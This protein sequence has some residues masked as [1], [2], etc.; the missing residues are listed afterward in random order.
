MLRETPHYA[1]EASRKQTEILLNQ[2]R[3]GKPKAKSSEFNYKEVQKT[4]A[5]AVAGNAELAVVDALVVLGASVDVSRRAST[6]MFKRLNNTDQ[7]DQRCIVLQNATRDGTPGMV[8]LLA[9]HAVHSATLDDALLIAVAQQD[10]EKT[11]ILLTTGI[12]ADFSAAHRPFIGAIGTGNVPLVALLLAATPA[13]RGPCDKCKADGLV[14]AVIGGLLPMV[15]MLLAADADTT[16]NDAQAFKLATS[17]SNWHIALAIAAAKR[18]LTP[19]QLDEACAI[20]FTSAGSEANRRLLLQICLAAGATGPN[21]QS[22]LQQAVAHGMFDVVRLLLRYGTSM[23]KDGGSALCSAVEQEQ[24]DIFDALLQAPASIGTLSSALTLTSKAKKLGTDFAYQL[25]NK[26]ASPDF[27]NGASLILA[28]QEYRLDILPILLSYTR[29]SSSKDNALATVFRLLP[30]QPRLDCLSV[31]LP[32]HPSEAQLNA[33]LATVA[34]ERPGDHAAI[35]LLLAHGA[36]PDADQGK[37]FRQA[38]CAHDVQLLELLAVSVS[39]IEMIYSVAAEDIIKHTFWR[40]PEGFEALLW[41]LDGGATPA[42]IEEAVVQ[43]A[44]NF[45]TDALG[46]LTDWELSTDIY[47]VAFAET[48]AQGDQWLQPDKFAIMQTLLG[49]GARGEPVAGALV[50][51]IE[52]Y[53]SGDAQETVM[54]TLLEHGA[55]VN[56]LNGQALGIAVRAGHVGLLSKLCKSTASSDALTT[57]LCS[58]FLYEHK[59]DVV[60]GLMDVLVIRDEHKAD[61]NATIG[62]M[63]SPIYLALEHYPKDSSIVRRLCELGCDVEIQCKYKIYGEEPPERVVRRLREKGDYF[64]EQVEYATDEKTKKMAIEQA[65]EQYGNAFQLAKKEL[66]PTNIDRLKLCY[67]ISEFHARILGNLDKAM[68]FARRAIEDAAISGTCTD[69]EAGETLD[70]LRQRMHDLQENGIRTLPPA[71]QQQQPLHVTTCNCDECKV[72][73]KTNMPCQCPSCL[74]QAATCPCSE[75]RAASQALVL[76]KKGKVI[77]AA[78]AKD[79]VCAEPPDSQLE[80][81]KMPAEMVTPLLFACCQVHDGAVS[82]S[83]VDTL[84]KFKANVN[85]MTTHSATTP[86]L[87]ATRYQRPDLVTALLKGKPDTS[88]KDKWLRSPLFYAARHGDKESVR[89]LLKTKPRVNDGSVHE[90]ARSLHYDVLSQL[91]KAGHDPNFTSTK[92]DGLTP[93]GELAMY[94]D[95]HSPPSTIESCIHALLNKKFRIDPLKKWHG[96]TALYLAMR[97][98]VALSIT[99]AVV[100]GALYDKMNDP[101][102][103]IKIEAFN[104]SP[105]MYIQ[106]GFFVGRPED[107]DALLKL[108][109]LHSTED[110]FYADEH[111][112]FQPPGACGLPVELEKAERRRKQHQQDLRNVWQKH[113]QQLVLKD[114]LQDQY[115]QHQDQKQQQHLRHQ[116]ERSQQQ[117]HQKIR[118][119]ETKLRLLQN[120]N[121][122]AVHHRKTVAELKAYENIQAVQHKQAV[123]RQEAVAEARK[124]AHTN[125]M[126]TRQ[127]QNARVVADIKEKQERKMMKINARKNAD[128]ARASWAKTNAKVKQDKSAVWALK[129][130]K[131]ARR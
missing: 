11:R 117:E 83:V 61:L 96:M 85:A 8:H 40:C 22:V 5:A 16:H 94:C 10:V 12:G 116:A 9:V 45:D 18:P 120:E 36:S 87:L 105:T 41:L 72:A 78:M 14:E 35:K 80:E 32:T 6:N 113:Q 34:C 91:L 88:I 31:L 20:A 53:V 57:A 123:H 47:S 25:L 75:C 127:E 101:A 73:A 92:H 39:N 2:C 108:L 62:G 129:Q 68:D 19:V 79:G 7:E 51:A 128:S 82:A 29:K 131:K 106:S 30:G 33:C 122:Q 90:A 99:R 81:T 71:R 100:E 17:T 55:D 130:K 86:L 121:S 119:A 58:A 74:E 26:G 112:A 110:A 37:A 97:N 111:L 63:M 114:Q 109:R 125:Q 59:S 52:A 43:A 54:D 84:L 49:R 89:A 56:Y 95:G 21:C 60:I 107:R 42:M 98:P 23:D 124:L 38:A 50:R 70:S 126:K 24:K 46:L 115:L 118:G 76:Y 64:A 93:L 4:F 28:I 15:R 1:T 48:V 102:N 3:L 67:T 104:Y 44:V 65:H 27:N 13:S 66:T 69:P 77:G 103:V